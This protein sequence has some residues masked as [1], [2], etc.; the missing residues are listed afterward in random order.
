MDGPVRIPT[1]RLSVIF[2]FISEQTD[3]QESF[4]EE[5]GIVKYGLAE[6]GPSWSFFPGRVCRDAQRA[7]PRQ[8]SALESPY[9]LTYGAASVPL[10]ES[11]FFS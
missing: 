11:Y 4:K 8:T 2:Q 5:R 6:E 10:D 3:Q 9:L 7:L 1:L